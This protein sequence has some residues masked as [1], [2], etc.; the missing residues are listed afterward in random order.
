MALFA[1]ACSGP[2]KSVDGG[3]GTGSNDSP[4]VA[5]PGLISVAT[6]SRN[7]NDGLALAEKGDTHRAM[8]AFW[9]VSSFEFDDA[10]LVRVATYNLATLCLERGWYDFAAAKYGELLTRDDTPPEL[11]PG[12]LAGLAVVF[13]R[14]ES[15]DFEMDTIG[16]ATPEVMSQVRPDLQNHA[17][18]LLGAY[19][20][21]SGDLEVALETLRAI[22]ADWKFAALVTNLTTAARLRLNPPVDPDREEGP[23][24]RGGLAGKLRRLEGEPWKRAALLRDRVQLEKT[25]LEAAA[26]ELGDG[27]TEEL[28]LEADV[29]M[30][31]AGERCDQLVERVKAEQEWA[32]AH[33][34]E[35]GYPES[36]PCRPP[37]AWAEPS[38]VPKSPV[39]TVA[40]SAIVDKAVAAAPPPDRDRDGVEDSA[41]RCPDVAG[42]AN[43]CPGDRDKDGVSDEN[44]KC[45]GVAGDTGNKGCPSDKDGDGDGVLDSKDECKETE[46]PVATNGCPDAD[47]DGVADRYDTCPA[48][49][50]TI[51][52]GPYLG[53]APRKNPKCAP[54]KSSGTPTGYQCGYGRPKVGV[55]CTCP[56]GQHS[57]LADE[58]IAI[59][60]APPPGC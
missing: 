60:W 3:V 56:S 11:L 51:K 13:D 40:V 36:Q 42:T 59:C 25:Q 49:K 20:Y 41:D 14:L 47:G 57:I 1:A 34:E 4:S 22:P 52:T 33:P 16:R 28:G 26:P 12:A 39:R 50:G 46:G 17:R 54:P 58:G 10:A 38:R 32:L 24:A 55:G 23:G 8:A 29:L 27:L 31:D 15:A 35:V 5:S 48:Q 21:R 18:F 30:H 37:S 44:D 9:R 45:P 6:P 7:F 2:A 19:Q 43:G 53:C